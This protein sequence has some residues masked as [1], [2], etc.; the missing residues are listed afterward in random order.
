MYFQSTDGGLVMLEVQGNMT[1]QE[2][3]E[4]EACGHC[5]IDMPEPVEQGPKNLD[6]WSDLYWYRW[7]LI[8]VSD[9]LVNEI[10][11]P[12]YSKVT[13]PY[14]EWGYIDCHEDIHGHSESY[15][16]WAF[17]PDYA[18]PGSVYDNQ[19]TLTKDGY[20]R[21]PG[22]SSPSFLK[23]KLVTCSGPVLPP[24]QGPK[25]AGS[26]EGLKTTSDETVDLMI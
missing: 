23:N 14:P 7:D 2:W 1:D 21:G 18:N 4:Y 13:D 25:I 9:T 19:V 8:E 17:S 24:I 15:V 5:D 11:N 16:H 10:G 26:W 20:W 22:G 6:N 3:Y 12:I